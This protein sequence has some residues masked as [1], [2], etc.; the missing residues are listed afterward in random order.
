MDVPVDGFVMEGQVLTG[1]CSVKFRSSAGIAPIMTWTGPAPYA[2]GSRAT[3]DTVISTIS[4]TVSRTMDAQNYRCKTN[5]TTQGFIA[6]DSASNAP[7]WSYTYNGNQ[8]FVHWAPTNMTAY[9]IQASYEID[10]S[11]S[12]WADANPLATY[13]WQSLRTSEFWYSDTFTTREDMVGYQLMRCTA[14]NTM[15]GELYTKDYFLDV[16]VNQKTTTPP[17]TTQSTTTPIPAV[18][19]CGDLT[20]RWEATFPNASMCLTVDHA[21]DARLIGLM[22]NGSDTYWLQLTG[23]TREGKYDEL[24]WVIIWPSTSIGVSSFAAEC[25]SCYGNETLLAN[26]ISRTTKD[27]DFCAAG[28]NVNTSPQYTFKRV[29]ISWPCSASAQQMLQNMDEAGQR[30]R[31]RRLF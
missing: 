20:G 18:A 12:C 31:G 30:V 29:P 16:Y 26:A 24:G 4:F 8:M 6:P 1:E 17:P 3:N 11:I 9:P 5:F 25:H 21:N 2:S 23:R 13:Q 10:Q 7:T 28:N 15:Q 22:M 27:S 19:P 14:S